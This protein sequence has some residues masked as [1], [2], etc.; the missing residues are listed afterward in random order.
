MRNGIM[1][2]I[3]ILLKFIQTFLSIKKILEKFYSNPTNEKCM[4]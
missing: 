1:K 3:K 2:Q 4:I